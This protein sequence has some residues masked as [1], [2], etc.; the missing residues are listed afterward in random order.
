MDLQ[1]LMSYTRRAMDDYH[2]VDEGD[3]VAVAVSGGKD[4]MA[5]ALALKGLERFYPG[6]FTL[7]AYTV[8]IGFP[9]MDYSPLKTFFAEHEIPYEVIETGIRE[10]VFDERKEENPCSLCATLRK[11]ALYDRCV[12]DGVTK[13]ALGHHREDTVETLLLSLI[14]EGRLNTFQPV[15]KLS[16]TG[17]GIIRPLIYVPERDVIGF[18]NKYDVPVLKNTCPVDGYTKRQEVEELLKSLNEKDHETTKRMFTAIQ[19]SELEGWAG[20]TPGSHR[21][22]SGMRKNL[23]ESDLPDHSR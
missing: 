7:R 6:K 5:L 2:M 17:L 20:F 16:R 1:K 19:R 12:A 18:V 11:G 22:Q 21:I 14:Y 9:N 15:T 10:I 3:V 23:T 4:S 8:S 13:V